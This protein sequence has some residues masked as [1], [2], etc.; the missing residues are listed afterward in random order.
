VLVMCG[1]RITG[2]RDPGNT[3]EQDMGLLMAGVSEPAL[4]PA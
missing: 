4:E 2:E 1:G 3:S